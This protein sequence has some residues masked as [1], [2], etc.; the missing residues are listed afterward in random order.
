MRLVSLSVPAF[1]IFATLALSARSAPADPLAAKPIPIVIGPSY[2][3]P[4]NPEDPDGPRSSWTQRILRLERLV[5]RL[6][7]RIWRLEDLLAGGAPL[8]S[9]APTLTNT[10]T[11]PAEPGARG[12]RCQLSDDAGVP[13]VARASTQKEAVDAVVTLCLRFRAPNKC[14][15]EVSCSAE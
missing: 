5:E 13:F 2:P 15:P 12:W 9:P 1:L 10:P 6:E 3:A 4:G 11:P 8:P 7:R 14:I